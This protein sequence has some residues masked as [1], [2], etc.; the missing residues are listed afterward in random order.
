MA[1]MVETMALYAGELPYG[2]NMV[3]VLRLKVVDDL[4][5]NK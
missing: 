5:Q 1:H 2:R 4:H 3:W